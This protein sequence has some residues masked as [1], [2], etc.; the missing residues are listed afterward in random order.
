MKKIAIVNNQK[1]LS[2]AY[3]QQMKDK[4]P[5]YDLKEFSVG[6]IPDYVIS[7]GGDGTLLS[8]F[9]QFQNVIDQTQF[10]GIHTGH[11]G[12]Y[13][14]WLGDQIDQVLQGIVENEADSISYPLLSV[15]IQL[16]KGQKQHIL[17]LNECSVRSHR[18]TM[19]CD[20]EIKGQFFETF[21][22][23]GLCIATP[24]GSTGL[25]KSLGGAVMH[26]RIEAFQMTEMAS[27]NNR[28]YRSLASPI[29]LPADEWLVLRPDPSNE[30]I[31]ITTDHLFWADQTIDYIRLE[32][33]KERIHFASFKHT[34]Y[35]NRVESSFIA[36]RLSE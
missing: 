22:G 2:I 5:T 23:D 17:A 16:A 25:N 8:A 11:L 10:I 4:L 28:V 13:T 6:D 36:N 35:W 20:V 32:L 31:D 19:V 34:H 18:K 1:P 7:I 26:P 14:D 3:A 21:R 29:I 33:A 30:W 27:V 24:T 15:D 9:H 12:F